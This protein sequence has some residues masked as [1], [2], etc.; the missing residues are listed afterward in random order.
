MDYAESYCQQNNGT[1]LS[2]QS[3]IEN[4]FVQY[5]LLPEWIMLGAKEVFKNS[6]AWAD[7]TIW[8]TFDN[9]DPLDRSLE[10]LD[11]LVMYKSSGLW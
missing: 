2:T 10:T 9:R 11:C 1:V 8:G 5:H 6:Y 3:Q 7:G 4:T